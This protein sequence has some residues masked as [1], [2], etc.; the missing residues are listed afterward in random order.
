MRVTLSQ[1][2]V[3]TAVASPVHPF[4]SD[5]TAACFF[6]PF[7]DAPSLYGPAL[8][9]FLDTQ[10]SSSAADVLFTSTKTTHRSIY[11]AARARVGISP[12]SDPAS[13]DVVLYNEQNLITET[14][15]SNV[16]FYHSELWM[17]PPLSTGCLPGV[18]RRWLLQQRRIQEAPEGVLT[19][20]SVKEGDWVLMFNSVHGC[21]LGRIAAVP[22]PP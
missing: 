4:K 1:A 19:K 15:I 17:T 14:S 6:K 8:T 18:L 3:L 21:R 5:P 12:Q 20:E 10:P 7:N 9:V 22:P 13:P 11:N 2:G 16:A